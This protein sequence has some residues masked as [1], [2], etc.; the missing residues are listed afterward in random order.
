MTHVRNAVLADVDSDSN[1]E[2]L[3]CQRATVDAPS[4]RRQGSL[5]FLKNTTDYQ[6]GLQ[7]ALNGSIICGYPHSFVVAD[8]DEQEGRDA[9][10][11]VED[12]DSATD[13]LYWVS[14][15]MGQVTGSGALLKSLESGAFTGVITADFD[16]DTWLDVAVSARNKDGFLR[17]NLVW[18]RNLG[19]GSFAAEQPIPFLQDYSNAPGSFYCSLF[20]RGLTICI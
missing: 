2:L 17:N 3:L 18:F 6:Q 19:N 14:N 8:L 9:V 10:Y 13:A 11:A 15:F 4:D 12:L 16:N 7:T 5:H 20:M 1:L